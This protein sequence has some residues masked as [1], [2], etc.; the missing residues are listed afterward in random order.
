MKL[1]VVIVAIGCL[2]TLASGRQARDCSTVLCSADYKP[3][4]DSKGVSYT[5]ECTATCS[6]VK[7]FTQCPAASQGNVPRCHTAVM[8]FVYEACVR[9]E[10]LIIV[11]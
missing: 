6:G 9:P 2:A 11:I 7:K 10:L 5:N 3:V 1:A 4:C 8:P